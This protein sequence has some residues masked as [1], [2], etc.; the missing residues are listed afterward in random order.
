MLRLIT[1]LGVSLAVAAF[2]LCM[3]WANFVMTARPEKA[4]AISPQVEF[5]GVIGQP[6]KRDLGVIATGSIHSEVFFLR[7]ESDTVAEVTGIETECRCTSAKA[8]PT[9]IE[10]NTN[11]AIHVTYT[12]PSAA[13][14][15]HRRISLLTTNSRTAISILANVREPLTVGPK[16]VVF[17]RIGQGASVRREIT[18]ESYTDYPLHD[19]SVGEL[20]SWLQISVSPIRHS[21]R[22]DGQAWRLAI[23]GTAPDSSGHFNHSLSLTGKGTGKND[24]NATVTISMS[25]VPPLSVVPSQLLFDLSGAK[26]REKELHISVASPLTITPSDIEIKF[27]RANPLGIRWKNA[28]GRNWKLAVT[29]SDDLPDGDDLEILIVNRKTMSVLARVPVH[30]LNGK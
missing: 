23:N 13:A 17:G 12:A 8:S 26:S 22:R 28:I 14:D 3:A 1:I 15:D 21:Q 18:V 24:V 11:V 7:N 27:N 19:L 10:P 16:S 29:A 2:L 9:V 6:C 30:L 25:S 5:D 20:P 4:A